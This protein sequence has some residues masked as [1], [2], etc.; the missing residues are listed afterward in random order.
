MPSKDLLVWLDLEMSGLDPERHVILEIGLAVTDNQLKR[1]A[2]S[3]AWAIHQGEDVLGAMDPWCTEHHGKSGLTQRCRESTITLREAEK[4]ALDFLSAHVAPQSSPLCGN[5][6]GQDRRFLYKYMPALSDFFHYRNVDVSSIK[7][8]VR[9]WYPASL[10]A[11]PKRKTHSV[12]EDIQE[13]IEELRHYR[14]AVFREV[15]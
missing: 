5:S 2:S 13:S 7:E 3:P 11:P 14:K 15:S 1:V 12:M 4:L 8:L 10:A 6:I 9:R